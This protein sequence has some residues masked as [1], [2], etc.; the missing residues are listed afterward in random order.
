MKILLQISFAYSM[1]NETRKIHYAIKK[2][3]FTTIFVTIFKLNKYIRKIKMSKIHKYYFYS[4]NIYITKW[5][6]SMRN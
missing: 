2:Y 6:F 3:L 1:F 5:K 4:L